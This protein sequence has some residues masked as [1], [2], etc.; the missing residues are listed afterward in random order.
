MD[1]GLGNDGYINVVY[2]CRLR[3][4]SGR[5]DMKKRLV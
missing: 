1:Q 5:Y 2:T 4:G 3:G